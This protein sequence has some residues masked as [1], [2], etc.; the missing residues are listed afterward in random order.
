MKNT[1]NSKIAFVALA[2]MLVF[3]VIAIMPES[4]NAGYGYHDD[5]YYGSPYGTPIG[6]QYGYG[7]S[8]SPVVVTR[9]VYV[10]QPIYVTQPVV[11]SQPVVVVQQPVVQ[12]QS[13]AAS[14]SASVSYSNNGIATVIWSVNPS[15]GNGYYNFSWSGTDGLMGSSRSAYYNYSRPGLKYASVNISSAGHTITV[16]CSPVNIAYPQPIYQPVYQ[17]PVYQV[18]SVA[19]NRNLDIGCFADPTNAKINQPVNWS[20]EVTGG[21]APYTYS[22]SGS[23]NLSGNQSSIIKYYSTSGSKSA[24]VTVTSADGLT[25]VKACS[26]A[27]TIASAYKAPVKKVV[28]APEAPVVVVTPSPA[29]LTSSSAA[30]L[31]SLANVPWGWVAIL[32][33]LVLFFTVM[34]LIFNR[35]KI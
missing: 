35:K 23:D 21:I 13:I 5:Y 26:N 10:T 1:N 32:I 22:W 27:I 28:K 8:Y 15:G 14:C 11:V 6:T 19:N 7:Y 2:I 34:Y 16:N 3:G 25:G 4:A 24:I 29:P 17:Q 12:Y 20:V 9:P 33:I 30:S 18:A 31:F